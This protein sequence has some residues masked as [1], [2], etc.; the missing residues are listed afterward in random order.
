MSDGQ[1]RFPNKLLVLGAAFLL[2]GVVLL[3]W[4][5][6]R[7]PSLG[8]LWPVLLIVPGLVFLYLVFL[9]GARERYI[10]PGMLLTLG[11]TFLLLVTTTIHIWSL[12]K[13]W[14]VF[15]A[16]TGVSLFAYGMSKHGNARVA[17]IIPAI[18]IVALAGVFLPFSLEL[19]DV[20]FD[21]F[22]STWWPTLFI[23]VGVV[24]TVSHFVRTRRRKTEDPTRR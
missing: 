21:H 4:S 19:V 17:M 9:R 13:T 20:S 6:G 7:L 15:M 24:L 1:A 3:L 22:V 5:T 23:L 14:P 12:A 11:G 16:I 2:F 18:S 8:S 10:L